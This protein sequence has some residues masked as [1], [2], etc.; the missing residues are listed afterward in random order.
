M[1]LAQN[2]PSNLINNK[3][4]NYNFLYNLIIEV[5]NKKNHKN[6]M[7]EEESCKVSGFQMDQKLPFQFRKAS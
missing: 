2:F 3:V 1:M 4:L 5:L 6:R 7:S